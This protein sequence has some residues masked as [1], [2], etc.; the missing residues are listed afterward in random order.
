MLKAFRR[1]LTSVFV[2]YLS[3][4]I[5][6]LT[7][8][9]GRYMAWLGRSVDTIQAAQNLFV[10]SVEWVNST[11]KVTRERLTAAIKYATA[12]SESSRPAPS[13]CTTSRKQ[14]TSNSTAPSTKSSV[15]DSCAPPPRL[16]P[17]PV[18][19]VLSWFFG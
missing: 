4:A 7:S 17:R 8:E 19:V 18:A 1:I 9:D 10:R 3:F 14:H 2:I 13:P 15:A 16:L 12:P 11:V 6:A 5:F